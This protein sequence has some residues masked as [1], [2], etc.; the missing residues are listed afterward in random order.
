MTISHEKTFV[1]HL[2][3]NKSN[4]LP[5]NHL[6]QNNLLFNNFNNDL[7]MLYPMYLYELLTQMNQITENFLLQMP[8]LN[9]L[10][11]GNNILGKKRGR[12]REDNE[13]QNNSFSLKKDDL[14]SL[15]MQIGNTDFGLINNSAL[16]MNLNL[17]NIGMV[18]INLDNLYSN[19]M[20]DMIFKILF[21][22]N[23]PG[24][25]YSCLGQNIFKPNLDVL[26]RPVYQNI[27]N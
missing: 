22:S 15:P 2:N 11:N 24:S 25:N 27:K 21:C 5:F 12:S 16:S 9:N 3:T 26:N 19:P 6:F 20:D 13:F 10:I 18:F 8:Q 23:I 7:C 4:Y 17:C 14:N 1:S